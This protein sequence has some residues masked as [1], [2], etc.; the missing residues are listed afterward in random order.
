M[1]YFEDTWHIL[2]TYFKTNPYFLTQHHLE[3]WNDF[4]VERIKNTIKV[5]NP[6]I[7]IKNQDDLTHEINVFIGGKDG[8]AVFLNKPVMYEDG[9]MKPLFPNEA[10]LRDLTYHS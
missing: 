9:A 1:H 6:F 2:D 5:L 7:I 4:V 10:R 8:D 3:S